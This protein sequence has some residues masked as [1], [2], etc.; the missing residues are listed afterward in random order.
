MRK[1]ECLPVHLQVAQRDNV[2]LL[3]RLGVFWERVFLCPSWVGKKHL[4][5]GRFMDGF[6]GILSGEEGVGDLKDV[7][8]QEFPRQKSS[9]EPLDGGRRPLSLV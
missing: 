4:G 9:D 7:L 6:L 8:L 2:F 5:I 1:P 3:R